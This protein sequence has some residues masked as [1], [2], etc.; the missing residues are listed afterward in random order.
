MC[1]TLMVTIPHKRKKDIKSTDRRKI[2]YLF[3]YSFG[4]DG[5]DHDNSLTKNP[6]HH[7]ATE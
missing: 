7:T 2:D 1:V 4:L 6:N 3:G 5:L